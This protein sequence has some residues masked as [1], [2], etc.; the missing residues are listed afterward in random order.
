LVSDLKTPANIYIDGEN[1]FYQL[2][3][4]LTREGLIQERTELLKIDLISLFVEAVKDDVKP[5]NVRYYGTKLRIVSGMGEEA[6]EQSKKMV[7][8]KTA[9]GAWLKKQKIEYVTAGNL[10]ARRRGESV[11]FQ[12]KGVDVTL[13]VDMVQAAYEQD[14]L[15]FVIVSS[16]SDVIPALRIVKQR[17]HKI[18]YVA[19]EN[20]LN[21]AIVAHADDTVTYSKDDIVKSFSEANK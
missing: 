9:W 4:I 3:D 20:Q 21:K 6:L 10:K 5:I 13:A 17:G 7:E 11:V 14:N 1:L 15:H 16:D 12:E 2:V 19:Y 8:Q 18:T